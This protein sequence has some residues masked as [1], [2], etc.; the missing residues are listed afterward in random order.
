MRLEPLRRPAVPLLPS[1]LWKH[2]GIW[3]QML[4]AATVNTLVGTRGLARTATAAIKPN[5]KKLVFWHLAV[6]G[7][8]V[9]FAM[10][11]IP[12]VTSLYLHSSLP[13]V[14]VTLCVSV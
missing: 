14:D 6:A 10:S 7:C 11:T 1:L 12:G 9:F 2:W 13:N 3:R 4:R 8:E 5:L